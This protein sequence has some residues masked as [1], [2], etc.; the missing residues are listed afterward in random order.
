MV[1]GAAVGTII[2]TII[3]A[4]IAS[5]R[6]NSVAVHGCTPVMA[7]VIGGID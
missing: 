1:I 4:H 7:S 3:T 2:A 5:L 6:P